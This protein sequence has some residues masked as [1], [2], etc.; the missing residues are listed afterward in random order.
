MKLKTTMK[1][2]L[3]L[4][5]M[6][7]SSYSYGEIVRI[8]GVAFEIHPVLA[9]ILAAIGVLFFGFI[10]VALF[11]FERNDYKTFAGFVFVKIVSLSLIY[12][13]IFLT[14]KIYF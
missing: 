6:L 5:L 10:G 13:S 4:F 8:K 1:N 14:Y 11:L 3:F 2:K 9:E 12:F 7:F